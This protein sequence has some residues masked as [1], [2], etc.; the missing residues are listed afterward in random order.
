MN[1]LT[2]STTILQNST[3][4]RENHTLHENTK[5]T[6]NETDRQLLDDLMLE[7]REGM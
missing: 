6:L 2:S 7:Q 4:S 5:D 3:Y 1:T